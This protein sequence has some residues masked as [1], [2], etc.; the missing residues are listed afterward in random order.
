MC[1]AAFALAGSIPAGAGSLAV[2][3]LRLT[4]TNSAEII[5]IN[6]ENT[7]REDAL[8][9]AETFAWTQRGSEHKLAAT[10][11]VVA[12]PPVFR[13]APGAQQLVRVGLT[14]AFTEKQEQTFR[15]MVTEVPTVAIPG[16]VAVAVRHSL[17]IF[18][19]PASTISPLLAAT[20]SATGG[21]QITNA[22]SQH[23]RIQGWRL[24]DAAGAILAEDTGPGYL[25]AGASQALA[26]TGQLT[27]S[28]AVF[29]ADSDGRILKID[30]V[31]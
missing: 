29:E 27:A 10:D 1:L 14:R 12:V 5:S 2:A 31:D 6:V 16:T 24:R 18:V 22:G 9:Q 19:R 8:V 26:V 3:P 23:I 28:R 21:L 4:F 7:G 17:P 15:L 13:L 11:D 25:L 30:V 20:R